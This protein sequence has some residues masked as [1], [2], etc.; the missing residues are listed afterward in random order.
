MNGAASARIA[1]RLPLLRAG[2]ERIA[3]RANVDLLDSGDAD[4]VLRTGEIAADQSGIDVAIADGVFVVTCRSLPDPV[5]W[6]AVR[7]VIGAAVT[8]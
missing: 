5:V 7:R 6:D 8:D 4:F 1:A 2:L 3:R